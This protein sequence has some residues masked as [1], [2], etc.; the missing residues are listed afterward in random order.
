MNN[1]L[2]NKER[3]AATR[4]SGVISLVEQQDL[5]EAFYHVTWPTSSSSCSSCSSTVEDSSSS[6][7]GFSDGSF[8]D[9]PSISDGTPPDTS[10]IRGIR[11]PLERFMTLQPVFS[12]RRMECVSLSCSYLVASR[13]SVQW[14]QR[15]RHS[16]VNVI[17]NEWGWTLFFWFFFFFFFFFF[18]LFLLQRNIFL[19]IPLSET[20]FI[21]G[22]LNL[23]GRIWIWIHSL[24]IELIKLVF[25]LN[26]WW[27]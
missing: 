5:S 1:R 2:N 10:S 7:E 9:E 8:L 13:D 25:S 14:R 18:F 21:N 23:I 16:S 15:R 12:W 20:E 26:R 27:R 11:Q 4:P 24:W 6:A 3:N 19:F 17:I 22:E